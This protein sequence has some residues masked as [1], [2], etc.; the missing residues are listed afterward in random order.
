MVVGCEMNFEKELLYIS[1]NGS[2][3]VRLISKVLK[4]SGTG[5]SPYYGLRWIVFNLLE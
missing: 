2:T 4:F 5:P 3:M 1:N